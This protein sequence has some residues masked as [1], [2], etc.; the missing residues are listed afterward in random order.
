M[1]RCLQIFILYN[2]QDE[3][4]ELR[5]W[6][7]SVTET[8]SEQKATDEPKESEITAPFSSPMEVDLNPSAVFL[9]QEEFQADKRSISAVSSYKTDFEAKIAEQ[10]SSTSV[11]AS[12]FD[13]L[14]APCPRINPA[15]F[16]K[17]NTVFLYGGVTELGEV[18]V[19]LGTLN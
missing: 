10:D 17:G 2:G 7:L 9:S 18:E 11:Y 13:A 4:D 16:S 14:T 1:F 3:D 19:T 12:Y 8:M 15:I 5:L 6:E